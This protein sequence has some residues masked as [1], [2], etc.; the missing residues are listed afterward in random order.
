MPP[1]R[2]RLASGVVGMGLATA[3][4]SRAVTFS[5]PSPAARP[6]AW[7]AAAALDAG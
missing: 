4:A 1:E 5:S 6:R 2:Q 3:R 7:R